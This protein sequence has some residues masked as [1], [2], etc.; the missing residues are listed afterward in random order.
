MDMNNFNPIIPNQT[1]VYFS[2]LLN[3]DVGSIQDIQA[4]NTKHVKE[5]Q[6]STHPN[7]YPPIAASLGG[8]LQ[9]LPDLV[10]VH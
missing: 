9:K 7:S 10:Q 4:N 2:L 8:A 5:I 3:K 6:H 1:G